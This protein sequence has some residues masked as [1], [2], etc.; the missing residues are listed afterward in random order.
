MIKA[1]IPPHRHPTGL[2]PETHQDPPEQPLLAQ[3]K[4]P[5]AKLSSED[6]EVEELDGDLDDDGWEEESE[7]DS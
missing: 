5:G 7:N 1:P 3:R 2:L 4:T 6:G